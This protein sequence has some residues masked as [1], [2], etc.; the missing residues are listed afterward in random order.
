MQKFWKV[1][2]GFVRSGGAFLA[3]IKQQTLAFD[4]GEVTRPHLLLQMW[5]WGFGVGGK[6]TDGLLSS[7]LRVTPLLP[8]TR[9]LPYQHLLLF[10]SCGKKTGSVRPRFGFDSSNQPRKRGCG[11]KKK[12]TH[13]K[14]RIRRRFYDMHLAGKPLHTFIWIQS[15]SVRV[16]SADLAEMKNGFGFLRLFSKILPLHFFYTLGVHLLN[17]CSKRE[18]L[19]H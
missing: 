4:T 10:H 14:S 12:Q 8:F 5:R 2:L 1:K 15:G 11:S 13:F 19:K 17:Q 3:F 6:V 18:Y 16:R 9:S 7:P